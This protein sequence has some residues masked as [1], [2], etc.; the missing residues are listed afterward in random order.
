MFKKIAA[1]LVLGMILLSVSGCMTNHHV[2]GNG[3][4]RDL[5]DT[6]VQWYVL[7]GLI[8]LGDVD[9]Q[10]MARGADDYEINT[11]LSPINVIITGFLSPL[12][13]ATR[14][15]EVVR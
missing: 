6:K 11:Y 15:V 1:V 10:E 7:W 2:I 13:I 4:Q 5:V 9:S 8:P 12:T 3:S 14:T